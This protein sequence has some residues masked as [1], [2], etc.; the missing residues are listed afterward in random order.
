MAPGHGRGRQVDPGAT[1]VAQL[2]TLTAVQGRHLFIGIQDRP[3]GRVDGPTF[4]THGT[5]AV[6][7]QR[8]GTGIVQISPIEPGAALPGGLAEQRPG[9]MA[10]H[11]C[12]VDEEEIAHAAGPRSDGGMTEPR[13]V[14]VT[15]WAH[16]V[17]DRAARVLAQSDSGHT[18]MGSFASHL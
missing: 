6:A 10:S 15:S 11:Q 1:A 17:A 4:A 5:G 12:A 9:G 2:P 16:P 14:S 7:G 8:V 3:A 13:R 18:V